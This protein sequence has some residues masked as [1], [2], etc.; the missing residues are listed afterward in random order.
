M[1]TANLPMPPLPTA[2][3][4]GRRLGDI[5]VPPEVTA[6]LSGVKVADEDDRREWERQYTL[7]FLSSG[8]EVACH[9]TPDGDIEILHAADLDEFVP[10]LDSLAD[11]EHRQVTTSGVRGYGRPSCGTRGFDRPRRKWVRLF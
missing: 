7:S 5:P 4:V 6:I 9:E 3:L 8:M 1:A 10:W 11:E 2:P